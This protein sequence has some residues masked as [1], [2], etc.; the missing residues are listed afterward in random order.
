MTL[1]SEDRR[2]M[3]AP[4]VNESQWRKLASSLF[5]HVVP[6]FQAP[7]G[8]RPELVGSSLYLRHP[9]GSFLVTAAHVINRESA[10]RHLYC[11]FSDKT[12]TQ[13]TGTARYTDADLDVAVVEMS[14][15]CVGAAALGSKLPLSVEATASFSRPSGAEYLATGYPA[16]RSKA[17]PHDR[18]VKFEQSS[19]RVVGAKPDAY[20]A[21]GATP[22]LHLAF[23]LDV[24]NMR[25]PG[26]G[27]GRIPDPHGMSGCPMWELPPSVHENLSGQAKVAGIA[28]EHHS[29]QRILVAT[30]IGVVIRL[31]EAITA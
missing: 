9:I 2:F 12:F 8:K 11:T 5:V 18:R 19:F 30:D 4:E 23:P 27:R 16:S 26:G 31:I 10:T 25:F 3:H 6:L 1:G 22:M 15:A 7:A 13:L 14:E 20:D 28:I 21:V 29:A 17:N 24:S